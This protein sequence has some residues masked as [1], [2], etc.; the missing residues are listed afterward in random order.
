MSATWRRSFSIRI[1]SYNVCYTKLLRLIDKEQILARQRAVAEFV[2]QSL[3]RIDLLDALDG[4]Y[5][6]E[7]LNSKMSMASANAKD[8]AALR[9]SLQKLP[10]IDD[11]LGGLA[12][13]DAQDLK[14][15][16]DL[17]P[18]LLE[19]LELAIVDDPPFVLRDGGI[20]T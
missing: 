2:D 4:V 9:S 10:G 12:N 5:D 11:L 16:I 8:L 1:T 18:E 6:L 17:L 7:R 3:L 20:I 14:G 13:P 19:L 15:R